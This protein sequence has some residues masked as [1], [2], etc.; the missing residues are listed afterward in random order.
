MSPFRPNLIA[1]SLCKIVSV[2][3]NVVEVEKIDAFEGTPVLDLKPYAPGQDSAD[4]SQGAGVGEA[5]VKRGVARLPNSVTSH[6]MTGSQAI[7][8]SSNTARRWQMAARNLVF[9]AIAFELVLA[10]PASRSASAGEPQLKAGDFTHV[11]VAETAYYTV[12][13][14]QAR[15]PMASSSPARR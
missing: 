12:S 10:P 9:V 15:P 13:P 5:E 3:E 6:R 4:G 7:G 14:A 2:K 8:P 1:L 11:V